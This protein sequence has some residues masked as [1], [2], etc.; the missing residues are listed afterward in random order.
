MVDEATRKALD[1][2]L[3]IDITTIG[4]ASGVPRRIE[5]WFHRVGGRFY[6]TG[7]PG[8]RDWYANLLAEPWFTFHLKE[9]IEADVK[10]LAAPVTDPATRRRVLGEITRRVG[11]TD[12]LEQWVEH[13]PL[14]EVTFF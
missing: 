6:I 7:T 14:V 9:T 12:P 13:S 5:I 10:A 2:D 3:T 4:R 1:T 8:R 11:A